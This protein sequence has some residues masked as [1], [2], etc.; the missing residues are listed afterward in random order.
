MYLNRYKYNSI[1]LFQLKLFRVEDNTHKPLQ[2]YRLFY[3]WNSSSRLRRTTKIIFAEDV[4]IIQEGNFSYL[5]RDI[6][7]PFFTSNDLN[8]VYLSK[9]TNDCRDCRNHWIQNDSTLVTQVV[10]WTCSNENIISC[11]DVITS[12]VIPSTGMSITWKGN[13]NIL[14]PMVISLLCVVKQIF[15]SD[16]L[17]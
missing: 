3:Y 1:Q 16:N 7:L 15:L 5:N 6:F 9:K 13:A 4:S 14:V 11:E 2:Y 17:G 10:P 12:T 8:R